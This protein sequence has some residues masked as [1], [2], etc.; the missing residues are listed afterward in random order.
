[1]ELRKKYAN[2]AKNLLDEVYQIDIQSKDDIKIR[3]IFDEQTNNYLLIMDGWRG[4][5][6]LYGILIHLQVTQE[7]KIWVHQ[8]NTDTIIIDKLLDLGVPKKDIVVGFHAP[9]MRPDTDFAVA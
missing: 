7:G 6:R 9:I 4:S 1:M 3:K 2:F 8:D 5:S